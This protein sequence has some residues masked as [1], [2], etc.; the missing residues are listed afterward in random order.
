MDAAP[1]TIGG[2]EL[3]ARDAETLRWIGRHGI[4]SA[5]QVRRARFAGSRDMA[6]RRLRVLEDAGLIQ[7]HTLHPTRPQ[8]IAATQRG[9]RAV[10]VHL[11]RGTVVEPLLRHTLAVVDLTIDL[12]QAYPHARLFTEREIRRARTAERKSGSRRS[13][14]GRTPDALL[15]MPDGTTIGIE[16]DL[17]EKGVWRYGPLVRHYFEEQWNGTLISK[18]W[19]YL[20]SEQAARRMRTV[21]GR[22]GADDFVSV[23]VW[24]P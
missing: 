17:T 5:D 21:V 22:E 13:Q 8:L 7:R 12:E 6:Y 18:V 3:P 1:L 11:A 4:V 24:R 2:R 16:L 14:R 23:R 10:G 15:V 19:W 9:L 20:P